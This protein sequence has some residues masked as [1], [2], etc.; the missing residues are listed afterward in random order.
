LEL[1]DE[2]DVSRGD[3]LVSPD[4]KPSVSRFFSAMVVWLNEQ[5]LKLNQTYL[6][7]HTT[8]QVKAQ[9]TRIQHRVNV[10][11]FVHEPATDLSMNGIALVDLET[12]SLLFFDSYRR[13]RVT[14]SFIL[15]DPL[16]NAT[17]AAGMIREDLSDRPVA[18]LDQQAQRAST[19]EAIV[20]QERF[21]RNGHRPAIFCI[22]YREVAAGSV[23]RALFDAGF[24]TVVLDG[25]RIPA[26]AISHVVA[27]LWSAGFVVIFTADKIPQE[28]RQ[29]LEAIA[30]ESFFDVAITAQHHTREE[31]IAEITSHAESLRF[32]RL[33]FKSGEA[34]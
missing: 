17:V 9:V 3:M 13:S 32:S 1:E 23:E 5:P 21:E 20:P 18:S 27:S 34:Q 11:T 29:V 7:K 22:R 31:L 30:G 16:S 8:R 12:S 14:G 26:T 28:T 25:K 15:V 2:I 33:P 24:Q 10:N 4:A 19:E 6:A